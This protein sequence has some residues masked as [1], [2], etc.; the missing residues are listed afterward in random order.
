MIVTG[1]LPLKR[2][3]LPQQLPLG[4][5]LLYDLHTGDL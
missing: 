1:R 2:R 5:R 3:Q 4:A